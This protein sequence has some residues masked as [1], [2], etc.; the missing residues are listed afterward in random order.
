[1]GTNVMTILM[2]AVPL[3]FMVVFCVLLMFDRRDL[4]SNIKTLAGQASPLVDEPTDPAIKA[5]ESIVEKITGK[6]IDPADIVEI[7]QRG[8]DTIEEF[9]TKAPKADA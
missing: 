5:I 3:V 7:F 9:D 4:V 8:I 6:D 1:M 2:W